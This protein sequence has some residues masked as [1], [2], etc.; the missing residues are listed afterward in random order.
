MTNNILFMAAAPSASDMQ[1]CVDCFGSMTMPEVAIGVLSRAAIFGVA[2]G[3]IPMVLI[4]A[5]RNHF[6]SIW[7][8]PIAGAI[9]LG[10]SFPWD[11]EYG[12]TRTIYVAIHSRV[13]SVGF[14]TWPS[15][16]IAPVTGISSGM[17]AA[18]ISM[19]WMRRQNA[20]K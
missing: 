15:R 1:F 17:V 10:F 14:F 7:L 13:G 11:I 19:I 8:L 9:F 2:I 3:A 6:M 4:R 5:R 12:I 16:W 20:S 18:V